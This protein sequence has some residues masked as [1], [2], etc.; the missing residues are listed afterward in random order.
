MDVSPQT[1]QHTCR[2]QSRT[3]RSQICPTTMVSRDQVQITK[4]SCQVLLLSPGHFPGPLFFICVHMCVPVCVC[5]HA[6]G[7][8]CKP[9]GRNRNQFWVSSLIT[10]HLN[11]LTEPEAL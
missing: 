4:P 5:T 11:F 10:L 7:Y 9:V 3:F 6:C 1:P 8:T 2:G